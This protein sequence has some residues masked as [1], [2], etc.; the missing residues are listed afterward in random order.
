MPDSS[1]RG[2]TEEAPSPVQ[3]LEAYLPLTSFLS[4]LLGVLGLWTGPETPAAVQGGSV[5]FD[6]SALFVPLALFG[7]VGFVFHYLRFG[8]G[9]NPGAY[10]RGLPHLPPRRPFGEI[11]AFLMM[12]FVAGGGGFAG[13]FLAAPL[14]FWLFSSAGEG[15]AAAHLALK[16]AA[17]AGGA[18][19]AGLWVLLDLERYYSKVRNKFSANS[20]TKDLSR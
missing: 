7:L 12:P 19:A 5:A 11:A 3:L 8:R 20:T 4:L 16:T 15:Y 14:D 13:L 9:K 1:P 17:T 10:F 18:L 2:S 6:A